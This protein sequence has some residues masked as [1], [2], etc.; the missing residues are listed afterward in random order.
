[1]VENTHL[2][3]LSLAGS[4]H[5]FMTINKELSFYTDTRLIYQWIYSKF[6]FVLKMCK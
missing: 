2:A 4:G 5:I 3:L 1:M 6:K